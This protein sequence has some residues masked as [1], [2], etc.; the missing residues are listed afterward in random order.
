MNR[1]SGLTFRRR[2][3]SWGGG[4]RPG[5][6]T[7]PGITLALL[8]AA[9]LLFLA[10]TACGSDA[11]A[12][13]TPPSSVSAAPAE[14]PPPS[15]PSDSPAAASPVVHTG[16]GA[17]PAAGA[18]APPNPAPPNPAPQS[19]TPA[20]TP[21]PAQANTPTPGEIAAAYETALINLY[22]DA[23]PSIVKIQVSV[24]PGETA[25]PPQFE[26]FRPRGEGS[27][28]VWDDK[29]H[30]VTNHHVID[31]AEEIAVFFADGTQTTATVVG[32]DDDSDLAVIRLAETPASVVPVR[33]G[34][35]SAVQVGQLAVAIGAP[36]G[37]EFTMTTGIVSGVGR[38]ISSQT[39][40]FSI[41]EVIQTDA[42]VN[43]GNSGGP[44][45]DRLGRVI[46]VNTQIIS[47][48]GV[49]AGVGLAVPVNLVRRVAPALIQDGK[50]EY[51]WLGISGSGLSR[52]MAGILDLPEDT[53]GALVLL[54]VDD[55]PADKAGLRGS[56]STRTV[57]GAEY[58]AGGDVITAIDGNRVTDMTDL[59]A[60]LTNETVPGDK[61]ELTVIR[62]DGKEV[63]LEVTLGAR[64]E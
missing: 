12:K 53:R 22:R 30:V 16:N 63:Q 24:T 14:P 55:S 10:L 11:A 51:S 1:F 45:L 47:D 23:L 37:Q 42:A 7:W 52:R 25:L 57:D 48:S 61:V 29:G 6:L 26:D 36:F 64:P 9:A 50:Y 58:P 46:G 60:Y 43:P 17:G 13:P 35:S 2:I 8:L 38:M 27:G 49:N 19:D 59:I 44:L 20:P 4:T 28:F 54:V 39:S 21:A 34:D 62:S 15:P 56:E 18:A 31:E 3:T 33:L 40:Q 32:S 5:G 41:P